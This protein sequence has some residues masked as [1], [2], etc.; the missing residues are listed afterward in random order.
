MRG[1]RLSFAAP[2]VIVTSASCGQPAPV[3]APEPPVAIQGMDYVARAEASPHDAAVDVAPPPI[4]APAG[5]ESATGARLVVTIVVPEHT[6]QPKGYVSCHD[7]GPG[8]RG[9]N[10]PRPQHHP[11]ERNPRRIMAI[12]PDGRGGVVL[13]LDTKDGDPIAS[14]A[15]V[16]TRSGP[17]LARTRVGHV[18]RV[19]NFEARLVLELSEA[20][21][22]DGAPLEIEA[23]LEGAT[24]SV[25]HGRII[26]IE[27]T[28]DATIITI[29]AGKRDGID[30]G[31]RLD[32]I[33][34]SGRPLKNG[35][36][37]VIKV[38]ERTSYAK[39]KL[40][41]D[42]VKQSG[43]VRFTPPDDR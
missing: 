4:D 30:R 5:L 21:V 26:A 19:G 16:L 1:R 10:P 18:D 9:C 11:E 12:E 39:V 20:Q 23:G 13:T 28:G 14:G 40:T 32:V 35:A 6:V 36:A 33:D 3:A 8:R 24:A 41:S 17:D 43:K 7:F 27:D 34:G 38:T 31:W 22:R 2:F 25:T 29:G 15:P 42:Q 37:V